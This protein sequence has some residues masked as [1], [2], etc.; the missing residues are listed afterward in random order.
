M[1]ILKIPDISIVIPVYNEPGTAQIVEDLFT[2]AV[3]TTIQVIVV[4]G[5]PG[6]SSCSQIR[7][8]DVIQLSS[9]PGRA[10][11]MNAGAVHA[12]APVLLF[13]HADTILPEGWAESILKSLGIKY[14]AGGFRLGI[15]ATGVLFR[16]I[17]V[18]TLFRCFLTRIPYGDQAIFIRKDVFWTI[19]G[20]RELPILEDVDIMKRLKQN[21]GRITF[22][23]K[24][25]L[26]SA[27]RWFRDGIL[28][29]TFRNRLIIF[30]FTLGFTPAFLKRLYQ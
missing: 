4:D 7:R 30:M 8:R 2:S 28:L 5:D 15:D 16:I 27:R 14:S 6:R 19:G 17:E 21:K 18:G 20:Y 1:K 12:T 29:S 10:I 9:P 22:V 13:L 25:A 23:N 24:K 26:T 3:D 11:Q